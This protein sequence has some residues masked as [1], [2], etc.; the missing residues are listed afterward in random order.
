MPVFVFLSKQSQQD[1][2]GF[3]RIQHLKKN[4]ISS[5]LSLVFS[6]LTQHSLSVTRYLHRRES[7]SLRGCGNSNQNV[8]C[9]LTQFKCR[10]NYKS[11]PAA[12]CSVLGRFQTNQTRSRWVD[13]FG[14]KTERPTEALT[15]THWHTERQIQTQ[16][17]NNPHCQ[18]EREV[19]LSHRPT[20]ETNEKQG[21][22]RKKSSY[23]VLVKVHDPDTV[24]P[25]SVPSGFVSLGSTNTNFYWHTHVD[26]IWWYSIVL[27]LNEFMLNPIFFILSHKRSLIYRPTQLGTC[28]PNATLK[29]P[30]SSPLIILL[31]MS[32]A[33]H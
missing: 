29:Q 28:G 22:N 10:I 21:G 18:D 16:C 31:V 30:H 5:P 9:V 33:K 20:N 17:L 2:F 1:T 26:H 3:I 4:K 27:S 6:L 15:H 25:S 13:K 12:C 23:L 8:F 19:S 11:L 32:V 14:P 7:K 24:H